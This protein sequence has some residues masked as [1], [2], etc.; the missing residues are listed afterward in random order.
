MCFLLEHVEEIPYGRQFFT[1][2]HP[3]QPPGSRYQAVL[4]AEV[5]GSWKEGRHSQP[6]GRGLPQ[7]CLCI[8]HRSSL[9]PQAPL[10]DADF[11]PQDRAFRWPHWGPRPLSRG[12]QGRNGPG[13]SLQTFPL[14]TPRAQSGACA[15]GIRACA[16]Q[17]VQGETRGQ[18]R[19]HGHCHECPL[20]LGFI[21]GT[22]KAC[23]LRELALLLFLT[24]ITNLKI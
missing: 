2:P 12:Q 9:E 13:L 14:Q 1:R 11:S 24:L 15:S 6:R 10:T 3:G 19:A 16:W 17:G 4:V 21:D 5:A 18:R 23:F 7:A 22:G 20:D 8:S